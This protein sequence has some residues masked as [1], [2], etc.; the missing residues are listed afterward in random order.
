VEFS[1]A[2]RERG[3]TTEV[4]KYPQEGHGGGESPA[5][6]DLATR[7]VGWFE[8]FLPPSRGDR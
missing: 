1:R 7:T 8:R 5:A 2:L 3:I 4:V 6:P